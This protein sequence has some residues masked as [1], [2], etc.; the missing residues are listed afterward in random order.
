[1]KTMAAQRAR[2][3]FLQ[4]LREA[5]TGTDQNF[6]EG[7]LTRSIALLAIP[8]I[9]EMGM[10][11]TFGIVDALWV[12]RLGPDALATVGLTESV[13]VLIFS[14]AMGLSMAATA[15]VARRIGEKDHEGASIAPVQSIGFG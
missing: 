7:G 10:E 15:T 14:I 4:F 9:L 2:G 3:G 6:T 5:L 11:S 13:V 12:G 1:M 8:T